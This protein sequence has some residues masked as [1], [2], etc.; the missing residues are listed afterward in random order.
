MY[1]YLFEHEG[2]FEYLSHLAHLAPLAVFLSN[3]K[4]SK[5][6]M[7]FVAYEPTE[8]WQFFPQCYANQD[9]KREDKT[10][11]GKIKTFSAMKLLPPH[12]VSGTRR[13]SKLLQCEFPNQYSNNVL[14]HSNPG[15]WN[16]MWCQKCKQ[17]ILSFCS[18]VKWGSKF[19]FCFHWISKYCFPLFN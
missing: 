5:D 14:H 16:R 3:F 17:L 19:A 10:L 13:N 6:W 11:F 7:R 15:I 18:A 1:L 8:T 2:M 9:I 12:W 4:D